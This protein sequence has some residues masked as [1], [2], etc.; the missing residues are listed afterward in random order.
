VVVAVLDDE[1]SHLVQHWQQLRIEA[2]A[3]QCSGHPK[4]GR[5]SSSSSQMQL[6]PLQ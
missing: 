2:A 5:S 1:L 6:Q 4:C 3:K